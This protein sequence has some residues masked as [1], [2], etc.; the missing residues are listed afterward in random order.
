[1]IRV[2]ENE[3]EATE[4]DYAQ[5]MPDFVWILRD[6]VLDLV[7]PDDNPITANEYLENALL[8]R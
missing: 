6:F 7:D 8:E 2:T 3:E 5:F 1:M 4:E